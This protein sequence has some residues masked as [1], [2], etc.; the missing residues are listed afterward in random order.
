MLL[1]KIVYGSPAVTLNFTYPPVQKPG[2]DELVADRQDTES[3]AGILQ[4]MLKKVVTFRTLQM[5]F[6]PQADLANWAAFIGY[7][8]KGGQFDYY[9][10]ATSGTHDT[11][12]LA[13]TDWN[14]AYAF[15]TFSKF[16]IKMRKVITL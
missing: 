12:T 14:P 5:D 3:T 15:R 16:K 4:T 10:D 11:W 7:A 6:V 8:I 1:P 13:D 9:P 2:T